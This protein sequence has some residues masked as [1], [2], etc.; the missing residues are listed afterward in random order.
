MKLVP[1]WRDAWRFLSVQ[2]AAAIALLA[3]AYD[4]LP[5]IRDYVP[6]GWVKWAALLVIAGRVLHQSVPG[7]AGKG[8][9]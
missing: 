5:V 7:D 1:D 8:A 4:Y 9:P 6:E 2:L 3:A